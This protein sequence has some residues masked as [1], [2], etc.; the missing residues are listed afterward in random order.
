MHT[1]D[2]IIKLSELQP[3]ESAVLQADDQNPILMQI[4]NMGCIPGEEVII[5][6][7]GAFG[8]PIAFQISDITLTVRLDDAQEI[9][10]RRV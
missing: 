4:M 2:D 10:V 5:R 8:D 3:N 1:T 6:R 9:A 7:V